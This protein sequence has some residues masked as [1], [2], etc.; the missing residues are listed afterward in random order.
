MSLIVTISLLSLKYFFLKYC[1]NQYG[2]QWYFFN[3]NDCQ[4]LDNLNTH[5]LLLHKAFRDS[6]VS[7]K[8]A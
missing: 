8:N 7:K 3:G 5:I 2:C 6:T 1:S 4:R